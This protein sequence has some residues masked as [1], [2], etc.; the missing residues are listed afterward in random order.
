MKLKARVFRA[1]HPG[2][3]FEAASGQG[4]AIHGGRFNRKGRSALYTSLSMQTAWTEAQQAFPFKAQP[5]TLCTYDVD[6][7]GIEDLTDVDTLARLGIDAPELACPWENISTLGQTPPTWTLAERLIADG[8]AGIIAPSFASAAGTD[9]KN[10]IFWNWSG[11]LPHQ[12]RV[13]DDHRRLPR[14]RSSWA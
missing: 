6:C 10:V 1:H 11:Q 14:D 12:V 13:I 3:A 8:V 5:V 4:A 7:D 2:W 9:A